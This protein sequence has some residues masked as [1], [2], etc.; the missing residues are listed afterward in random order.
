ME[1]VSLNRTVEVTQTYKDRV[2]DARGAA[3]MACG[4]VLDRMTERTDGTVGAVD[5]A[6]GAEIGPSR[7]SRLKR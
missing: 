2:A 6:A 1:E 7:K 3:R 4:D 5:T